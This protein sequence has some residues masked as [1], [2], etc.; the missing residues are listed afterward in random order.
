MMEETKQQ[1]QTGATAKENAA[2]EEQNIKNLE[3]VLRQ[4]IKSKTL[5]EEAYTYMALIVNEDCPKNSVELVS[6]VGDF[7]TDGMAYSEDDS[8]R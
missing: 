5:T 2:L 3:V 4:Y 7:M 8:M 6:L 1:Q